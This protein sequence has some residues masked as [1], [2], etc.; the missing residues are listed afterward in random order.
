MAIATNK[1]SKTVAPSLFGDLFAVPTQA[2]APAT[3]LNQ[4][5]QP[6]SAPAPEPTPAEPEPTSVA[7]PARMTLKDWAARN[8]ISHA[9]ALNHIK[10]KVI[11]YSDY[12]NRL[13]DVEQCDA[14]LMA[15]RVNVARPRELAAA[16]RDIAPAPAAGPAPGQRSDAPPTSGESTS[17][18]IVQQ[19]IDLAAAKIRKAQADAQA[20]ELRTAQARGEL[21]PRAAVVQR[22]EAMAMS[23]RAPL[24][25]MAARLGPVLASMTDPVACSRLVR[26]EVERALT[27]CAD[28]LPDWDGTDAG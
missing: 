26:D 12:A 20:S 27:S 7:T 2:V 9:A 14:L 13:V 21:V 19:T 17:A 22:V 23:I 6:P 18:V 11:A 10:R 25:S 24:Q 4:P 5:P 3:E 8:G 15:A 16:G 28:G 1:P